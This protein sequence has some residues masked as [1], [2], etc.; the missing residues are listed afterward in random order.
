VTR[1]RNDDRP[2]AELDDVAV[3][4][5]LIDADGRDRRRRHLSLD[6]VEYGLFPGFQ[7]GRRARIGA[8]DEGRVGLVRIYLDRAPGGDFGRRADMVAVEARQYQLC[9]ERSA[10]KEPTGLTET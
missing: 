2:A 8:A 5:L 3:R 10:A 1:R 9:P 4:H 6:P 7:A